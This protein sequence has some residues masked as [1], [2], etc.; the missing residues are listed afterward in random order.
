MA[1]AIKKACSNSLRA[2]RMVGSRGFE[3]RSARSERAASANCATSRN[4]PSGWT[5]TTTSRVK[6][7]ACPVHT[8]EGYCSGSAYGYRTRPSALATQDASSTPRPNRLPSLGCQRTHS[9]RAGGWQGIRT[10][11]LPGRTGLRPVSGPSARTTRVGD[12]ARI[13]TWIRELWRLGCSRCT[14]LPIE[15][16]QSKTEPSC[17]RAQLAY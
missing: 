8:T 2:R 11:A 17:D 7:P 14:T 6:S 10:Q 1:I 4:G 9:H 15:S 12:S 3:P 16:S 5:R 13:R